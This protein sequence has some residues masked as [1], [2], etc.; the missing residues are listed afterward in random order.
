[1]TF[2]WQDNQRK[3]TKR[4]CSAITTKCVTCSLKDP[5]SNSSY[6]RTYYTKTEDNPRFFSEIPRQ[7]KRWK[8]LMK[9]RIAVERINKQVLIDCGIEKSGV[10]TKSRITFW[11][12]AAM[13]VIHLK[14]QY[15]YGY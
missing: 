11:L 15:K 4:R 14:A 8:P 5:C 2:N 12:T 7:S 3:R 13:M 6:G 9:E 1:M 10:R